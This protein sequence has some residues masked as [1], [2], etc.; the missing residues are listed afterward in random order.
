MKPE[1]LARIACSELCKIPQR[2]MQKPYT[3]NR[4]DFAEFSIDDAEIRVQLSEYI[5]HEFT[6]SSEASREEVLEQAGLSELAEDFR[7][8]SKSIVVS[9]PIRDEGQEIAQ[10]CEG[11]LHTLSQK[12]DH[13]DGTTTYTIELLLG[14]FLI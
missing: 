6:V 13:G 1:A 3:S 5:R 8:F 4:G 14:S 11:N 7:R 9:A 10:V 2:V 12:I